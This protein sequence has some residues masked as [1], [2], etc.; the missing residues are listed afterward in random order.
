MNLLQP[1][2]GYSLH[3]Y[4]DPD[5]IQFRY[6]GVQELYQMP[7]CIKEAQKGIPSQLIQ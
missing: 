3:W 5:A 6:S 7:E 1:L 4:I 2:C